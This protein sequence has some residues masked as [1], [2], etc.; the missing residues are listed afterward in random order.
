MEEKK[1]FFGQ[2]NSDSND[3]SLDRTHYLNAR[4]INILHPEDNNVG[5]V[6]ASAGNTRAGAGIY[7]ILG[8]YTSIG[9][10]EDHAKNRFLWIQIN[11]N[12]SEPPLGGSD[13]I[14]CYE[15]DTDTIYKVLKLNDFMTG[16]IAYT[17][18]DF[19]SSMVVTG[20]YLVWTSEGHPPYK[21]NIDRAIRRYQPFY[22]TVVDPYG[23]F[24]TID[25]VTLAKKAPAH[26]PY[27]SS[28][29]DYDP[30]RGLWTF[31]ENY[32]KSD[33]LNNLL[34][35]DSYLFAS[36]FIYE[37]GEISTMS[38][39]TEV[40]QPQ[41]D[42]NPKTGIR[43]YY[44][45][46]KPNVFDVK[47]VELIAKIGN[48]GEAF[49][50][51]RVAG[52]QYKTAYY[53]FYNTDRGNYLSDDYVA[54][55]SESV[56]IESESVVAIS[57]KIALGNNTDGYDIPET[58]TIEVEPYYLG[59]DYVYD[60]MIDF[61]YNPINYTNLR[62]LSWDRS[63][64]GQSQKHNLALIYLD[65]VT[66]QDKVEG[67]YHV[68]DLKM[69]HLG[70]IYEFSWDEWRAS[71]DF[72]RLIFMGKTKRDVLGDAMGVRDYPIDDHYELRRWYGISNFGS[73]TTTQIDI[74]NTPYMSYR[75]FKTGQPIFKSS[76]SFNVGV[77]WY[78][79]QRRKTLV[80][81][82][83]ATV[84]TPKF[85]YN[86]LDPSGNQ[87]VQYFDWTLGAETIPDWASQY[88]IVR[89]KSTYD[90]FLQFNTDKVLY[91]YKEGD[92]KYNS[93]LYS[94]D[95]GNYTGGANATVIQERVGDWN[96]GYGK[97]QDFFSALAIPTKGLNENFQGYTWVEG[98]YITVL[99]QD[100]GVT[101]K[102]KITEVTGG[103]IFCEIVDIGE[104]DREDT[105]VSSSASSDP[106]STIRTRDYKQ[107]V[108]WNY[109]CEIVTPATTFE[110]EY[111][112]VSEVFDIDRDL[113]G[114]GSLSTTSGKIR[115][116]C[117]LL[118]DGVEFREVMNRGR[119]WELWETDAMRLNTSA[120]LNNDLGQIK[121]ETSLK[122]SG[123]MING[124]D[125]NNL[126]SFNAFDE[127]I[128][129]GKIGA[130]K[131]LVSVSKISDYGQVMLVV[132]ENETLSIYIDEN[133]LTDT[134]GSEQVQQS[135]KFIGSIRELKGGYGTVHPE[136]VVVYKGNAYWYDYNSQVVVRYSS[137]GL[138]PISG[139]FMESF[140]Q[141]ISHSNVRMLGGFDPKTNEYLLHVPSMPTTEYIEYPDDWT[142]VP[143]CE[144]TT[145]TGW[146]D[147]FTV[148]WGDH[149]CTK[150]D[151]TWDVEW[152]NT[153]ACVEEEITF[154]VCL[155]GDYTC[156]KM[157]STK[158]FEVDWGDATCVQ[159]PE[160]F[161]VYWG[162]FIC[163]RIND[164][165]SFTAEW[166]DKICVNVV[167]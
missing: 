19:I 123:N 35:E 16:E 157:D 55:A 147:G 121:N 28:R 150:K 124:T 18:D 132:G 134:E 100:L 140:F 143:V 93:D 117:Y 112:E 129:S 97:F 65:G 166:D 81:T 115:G 74:A 75:E 68:V 78:D 3:A 80:A 127:E 54:T 113:N 96:V 33:T 17:S 38:P 13:W 44:S 164:L 30:F 59:Q 23:N 24:E 72:G 43:V 48:N 154:P 1:I 145:V 31:K 116:D 63:W 107:Y 87:Y 29:W 126:S 94:F 26:P 118:I 105:Q 39:Y 119:R 104:I 111:Y 73:L 2:L 64:A 133:I 25:D 62:H 84:E 131:K 36:R 7:P 122:W 144:D 52:D 146:G 11:D 101:F 32:W 114:V 82:N 9:G 46:N 57:N 136:S 106:S 98:D 102:S 45:H 161:D 156:V 58:S 40:V 165:G 51:D 109:H 142:S 158:Y 159:L 155:W 167:V 91:A 139:Y 42:T 138:F 137:A 37:G 56:P 88:Q 69:D 10:V 99:R 15:K 79:P 83:N 77:A 22:H 61:G 110:N 12:G 89:T 14:M 5:D 135:T 148:T 162:D 103:Y 108:K 149:T 50:I 90:S 141:K 120:T 47:Y 92:Q 4:N 41:P 160:V 95:S 6:M 86:M 27:L 70:N 85:Q 49:V 152:Q 67:W 153:P 53:D 125:I 76:T 151:H 8:E 66:I 60:K 130:I 128:L 71:A 163:T 20:E 21:I 34:G